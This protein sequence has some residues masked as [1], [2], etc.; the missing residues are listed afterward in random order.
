VQELLSRRS[1]VLSAG[2]VIALRPSEHLSPLLAADDAAL[3][4]WHGVSFLLLL[5]SPSIRRTRALSALDTVASDAF[6][7][8]LRLDDFFPRK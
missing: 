5:Y 8:R 4:S 1:E 6:R 2:R 7:R 3:D